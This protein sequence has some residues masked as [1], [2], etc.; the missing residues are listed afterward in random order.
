MLNV[1]VPEGGGERQFFCRVAAFWE[2]A[3][4]AGSEMRGGEA[5]KF[6]ERGQGAGGDER[7]R[8]DFGGL[9]A[10]VV[11]F[12]GRAGLARGFHEEGGFAAV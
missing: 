11:D 9:D 10:G 4:A 7:G 5:E 1:H 12:G 8:G 6:I 2:E 3:D